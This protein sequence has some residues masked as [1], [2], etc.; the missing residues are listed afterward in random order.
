MVSGAP[1]RQAAD[2]RPLDRRELLART[3]GAV[4]AGSVIGRLSGPAF[5][6]RRVDPRVRDLRRLVA[7]P[8]LASGSAAYEAGRVVY[9]E[10]FDEVRPLAIVRPAGVADI[11]AV[12]RWAQKTGVAV[13][14]RSGG[15]SY[16]G[17]STGTGVVLD[18]ST[19]HRISV[20]GGTAV[21]GAGA[22]LIDVYA[23]LASK[24]RTIPAGSCST[25]GIGGLALGGGIGLVA[26]RFGTT[27]DNIEW[28]RIVT[29]DGRVLECDERRHADLFWACR[30]GGGRNFGIVT[31]FRF[32]AAR[33]STASYFFASWPWS[34]GPELI[35]A[36]QRWAPHATDA[37]TTLCRLSTGASGPALQVFG[38][39]LG[40]E[41]KIRGLLAPLVRAATPTSITTGT[42]H[43]LDLMLRWAG[44]LGRSEAACHLVA[45]HGALNRATFAAK[46]DYVGRPFPV[47]A[48]RALQGRIETRQSSPHGSGA[49]IMDSYGG[50]IA[51]VAPDATAFVH[52]APLCSMQ[53]LAYWRAP[54]HEAASL[55]WIRGF[56]GAMRPYVT[57]AAYQNYIDPDI[58]D[59]RRAYYG[60]NYPRLVEVKRRYDP[61]RL[62][63]F[64]QAI[65]S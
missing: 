27:S 38:Q 22:Q 21:V 55:A 65:G 23:A 45:E 64:P 28:L 34:A 48:V 26:R 62:F 14:P 24:G 58:T 63:R 25:V 44:C 6:A 42:S 31:D 9:N 3:A 35:P 19:L 57:G 10:R 15:H 59:W 40:P 7:G 20:E 18:L 41:A 1:V 2:V 8:V 53:Y 37:I 39:F 51:R 47:A 13:V 54:E 43:Y 33:A 11:Q 29:A 12:V 17:Y 61:D 49:L 50:A 36:W 16:A 52:R 60:S 4:V 5:A 46:S 32:R 30:G 56:H